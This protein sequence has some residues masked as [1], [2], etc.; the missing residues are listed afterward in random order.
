MIPVVWAAVFA[1]LVAFEVHSPRGFLLGMAS[2]IA[3]SVAALLALSA[4]DV[5]AIILGFA[6]GT[7]FGLPV[8]DPCT[9]G[10]FVMIGPFTGWLTYRTIRGRRGPTPAKQELN[11]S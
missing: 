8:M 2:G 3:L 7:I 4:R 5:F 10:P 11:A 9:G 6:V 1:P